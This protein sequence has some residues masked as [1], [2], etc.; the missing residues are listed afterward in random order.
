MQI[1]QKLKNSLNINKTSLFWGCLSFIISFCLIFII[2]QRNFHTSVLKKGLEEGIINLNQINL[3]I[4]YSRIDFSSIP[5]LDLAEIDDFS[6]Y[7]LNGNW[8]ISFPKIRIYQPWLSTKKLLISLGNEQE[9]NLKGKIYNISGDESV[10]EITLEENGQPE[11]L[12]AQL[13]NINIKKFAKIKQINIASRKLNMTMPSDSFLPSMENFLEIN[14]VDIDGLLNYPLTSHINHLYLKTMLMGRIENTS[15]L[16]SDIHNWLNKD[17][18]LDIS[19][20]TINWQP[21][22]MVGRGQLTFTEQ[23][24]PVL[25]LETSSKGMLKLIDD[26]QNKNFIDSKG[27]FV[28]KILLG[29]KAFKLKENDEELTVVTPINYRDKKLAVENFTIK[30]FNQ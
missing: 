10:L 16:K 1:N 8:K 20:F 11:L 6:L 18:Y 26:F 28:V 19:A 27:A 29:S 15:D 13:K 24:K 5:G 30:T 3:D 17:G 25:K 7:D 9:F 22:L 21:L 23:L 12:L 4:A 14:H 2:M